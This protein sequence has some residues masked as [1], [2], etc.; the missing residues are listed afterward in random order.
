MPSGALLALGTAI[1]EIRDLAVVA[2]PYSLRP[3]GPNLNV[4]RVIGRAQ[5]VL[6]SSHFERYFYAVN[7]EAVSFLNSANITAATIPDRLKLL[8]TKPPIDEISETGWE[9]R[10]DKLVALVSSDAW[11]WSDSGVGALSHE[12]LLAWMT[13]PKPRDLRRYYRYWGI[14]DIFDSITVTQSSRGNLWLRIQELVDR[15][16]NIAHGDIS[17]QATQED[18]KR[19]IKSVQTFC[20]RA[21]RHFSRAIA[22]VTSGTRPW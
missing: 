11:L 13:A 3:A 15:R 17:A 12:R 22:K 18:I 4:L 2:R 19:Y 6:L 1:G 14:D 21:D 10:A 16:N 9:N 20:E 5:V 7:E 8:H